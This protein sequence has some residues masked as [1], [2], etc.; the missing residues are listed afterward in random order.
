MLSV[1]TLHLEK[2]P[3]AKEK[4]ENSIKSS[5][6]VLDRLHDIAVGL[7]ASLDRSELTLDQFK[8]PN[9]AYLQAYKN[10]SRNIINKIKDLAKIEKE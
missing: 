10:G 6:E 3:K 2:D 9:W 8:D 7:E 4:F 5:K 1:W